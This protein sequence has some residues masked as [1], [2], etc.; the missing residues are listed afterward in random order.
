[1][2]YSVFVTCLLEIHSPIMLAPTKY[3]L[4]HKVLQRTYMSKKNGNGETEWHNVDELANLFS[5]SEE[6]V[7]QA[8][9]L[10]S[11]RKMVFV[12]RKSKPYVIACTPVGATAYFQ[13]ILLD[14]GREKIRSEVLRYLQ[15]AGIF[16]ASIIGI[17]T[18]VSNVLLTQVV[19]QR[20]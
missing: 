6:K 20:C 13:K 5:T 14:E 1:M 8:A 12:N 19:A 10:L 18:F 4:Q 15:M 7:L 2:I 16:T 9:H 17:L 3:I 11:E